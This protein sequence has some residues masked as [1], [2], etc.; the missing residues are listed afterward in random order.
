MADSTAPLTPDERAELEAL[1]AEKA[2]R[3]EE[4]RAAAERAEL[5]ALRAEAQA[6]AAPQP[7]PS[8]APAPSPSARPQAVDDD[9]DLAMPLGQKLLI[10]GLAIVFAIAVF[11]VVRYS[12]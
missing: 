12:G 7:A 9:D 1:R 6:A 4:R 2:R 8:E 10:A 5:E 3:E 11:Y